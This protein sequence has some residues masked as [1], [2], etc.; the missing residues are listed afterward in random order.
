MLCGR[1]KTDT[2][3]L[4][5]AMRCSPRVSLSVTLGSYFV[6]LFELIRTPTPEP[7]GLEVEAIR[8]NQTIRVLVTSQ[9]IDTVCDRSMGSCLER[10]SA[11]RVRFLKVAAAKWELGRIAAD[12]CV[13]VTRD[14]LIDPDLEA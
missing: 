6:P 10:F 8:D 9:A 1:S 13:Y 5:L 3:E 14:D 11:N 7:A 12:G 2:G 4:H